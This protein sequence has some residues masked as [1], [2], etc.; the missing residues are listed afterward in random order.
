MCST[1]NYRD[2]ITCFGELLVDFFADPPGASL[3]EAAAFVPVPGGA[4]ANVAVGVA[5]LGQRSAFIGKVGDDAFGRKLARVLQENGVDTRGL[6]FDREAR[7]TCVFIAQPTKEHQ[8]FLFFRNPGADMMFDEN[9]INFALL[10]RTRIFHFGSLSLTADPIRRA[11]WSMLKFLEKQGTLL[12]FDVNYR[13]TLWKS[14]EDAFRVIWEILPRIDLLKVNE[15]E[16]RLLTGKS[17]VEEGIQVFLQ[18]GVKNVVVT[19]GREGAFFGN[20]QGVGRVAGFPVAVVDTTGCGDSFVAGV[21]SQL[22]DK[23]IPSPKEF[24][25]IVFF[26]NACAALTAMKKGVIPAL[27]TRDQVESFLS[28]WER[29][30]IRSYGTGYS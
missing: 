12:S 26:A 30:G 11:L 29:G 25:K 20:R 5:R 14:R 4:P 19:L 24:E 10:E 16:L 7:T 2:S 23:L 6:R 15:E 17:D 27:P 8:E 21:L 13:P 28:E 3:E 22:S 9:D 1:T 18:K